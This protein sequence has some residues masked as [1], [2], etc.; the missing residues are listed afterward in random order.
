MYLKLIDEAPLRLNTV[1]KLAIPYRL[2]STAR[3][4]TVLSRVLQ[5][6]LLTLGERHIEK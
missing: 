1:L 2:D 5:V 3:T 6:L 4:S